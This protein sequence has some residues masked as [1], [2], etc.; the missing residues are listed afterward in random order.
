MMQASWEENVPYDDSP[1]WIVMIVFGQPRVL[2]SMITQEQFKT[3]E[4]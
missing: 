2:A 3:A 1:S 4:P